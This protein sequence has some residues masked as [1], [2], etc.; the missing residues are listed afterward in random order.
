MAN[1]KT[2]NNSPERE[3][4]KRR[5]RKGRHIQGRLVRQFLNKAGNADRFEDLESVIDEFE[6]G[7]PED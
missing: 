5:D 6:E 3:P 1:Q 2:P 7:L 4:K